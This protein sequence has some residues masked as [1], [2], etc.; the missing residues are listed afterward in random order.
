MRLFALLTAGCCLAAPLSAQ[1]DDLIG[2]WGAENTFGPLVRG[3][4]ILERTGSTWTVRV[5]GFEVMG[6]ITGDSIR[7]QLPDN[8]GSLRARIEDGGRSI[9]GHWIQPPGVGS[10]SDAYAS[11]ITLT[12]VRANTWRGSI[13]PLDDR[14]SLYLYIRRDTAGT[15]RGSFHNPDLRWNGRAASFRVTRDSAG[16]RLWD[17]DN[18]NRFTQPYDSAQRRIT[19]DF[20]VQ[21]GLMPR[22]RDQ[23]VGFRARPGR[24][25]YTY[26]VPLASNDGWVPASADEV[27]LDPGRLTALV[28]HII[29]IDATGDTAPL[30]HSVVVA[31]RGKLVLEEYFFDYGP[32]TPH[33]LRSASKTITGIMAGIAVD[34]GAI[35]VNTPVYP[36]FPADSGI[37]PDPRKA[38]ITL[39]NLLTHSSGLACDDNDDNSPGNEEKMGQVSRDYYHYTLDLPMARDPN[40]LYAYCSATMNLAGGAVAYAT[41]S[42]LPEFFDRNL[43]R[44]LG[45]TRYAMNLQPDGQGYSGGGLRLLPRDL[46]KFGQMYLNGGTWNGKRIVSER[47]VRTSIEDHSPADATDGWGWHRTVLGIGGRDYQEYEANGNG[48]QFLI[49]VPELELA[50]VF[51]AGNYLQYPIWRRFR[52]NWIG[53]FIA[54]K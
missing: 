44:P 24:P 41:R 8:Q 52:D 4:L 47:W 38:T 11:P 17:R 10:L 43:A 33:D 14:F 26:R 40:T 45:I 35:T 46:L 6:P 7:I 19:M 13:V 18:R 51:T 48:G 34:R 9:R 37:N 50:V 23:A 29:D 15:L 22:T 42:W 36:L 5:A 3:D 25:T 16:V 27:G 2:I 1:N 54:P 53:E 31:R 21:F 20:G 30:V 32:D 39:G 49:V 28:Q 12:Q